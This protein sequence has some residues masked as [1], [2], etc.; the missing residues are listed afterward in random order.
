MKT[1]QNQTIK[2]IFLI[3]AILFLS[4]FV[5]GC[6]GGALTAASWPG[7]SIEGTTAYIAYNRQ[8]YAVDINTGDEL[9]N[10]P[11][12]PD[13]RTFFAP[14][15]LSK[16]GPIIVGG[17]DN[18]VYALNKANGVEVWPEP[19]DQ[20]T[21]RII[22]SP[23]VTGDT[24]LIPSADGKL[25]ALDLLT[26]NPVW[27]EPFK[28][29]EALWSAPV[30][31]GERVLFT[32]LDHHVYA[33]ELSSGRELWRSDELG[34][35]ITDT[36][37]LIDDYLLVSTFGGKLFALES[38]N[39]E[40][41]WPEPFNATDWLWGSPAATDGVLYFG[42]VSGVINA[43][44]L[45]DGATLWTDKLGQAV[46]A[47]PVILDEEVYFVTRLGV[48]YAYE[49]ASGKS[50]WTTDLKIEGE[51]LTDPLISDETIVLAAMDPECLIYG[52][53][54]DSGAFKCIFQPEE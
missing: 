17:Y 46:V 39:G 45:S 13:R 37:T 33:L 34:S 49:T 50:L 24:V 19:F 3:G 30:V 6:S 5:V 27:A 10:F 36:P 29:Q 7:L 26:G 53:D 15:G 43:V 20:P 54:I 8:V 32:S 28:A 22:G 2:Y 35:A 9:W 21:D 16:D 52:V 38:Q 40:P 12:E 1:S 48:V 42:D 23:I 44:N 4:T 41:V 11:P 31:D 18:Q 51:L 25:Y 47:S 14:P